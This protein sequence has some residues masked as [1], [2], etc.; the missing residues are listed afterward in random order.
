MSWRHT[1]SRAS[2]PFVDVGGGRGVLLAA[3]LRAAEGSSGVLVDR[4]AAIPAAR[5][6]LESAG[7]ADRTECIEGD[8]FATLPRGA[9]AYV[10]SRILHDWDDADAERILTTCREAMPPTSRLLIVEAILPERARDAPAAIR[11][12]LHMM[13]LFGA[14]E[15]TAAEFETLLE[16]TGFHVERTGADA[17]TRRARCDRSNAG[18]VI[19]HET[20][21]SV[22]TTRA[23]VW[24]SN[25]GDGK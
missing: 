14:A 2:A 20:I 25:R 13:L 12:D 6:Y 5:A 11:M 24:R 7:L 1:T 3:I 8:F 15:R 16:R 22:S 17:I 18:G 23:T 21:G 10:L 19:S 4:P 9:D